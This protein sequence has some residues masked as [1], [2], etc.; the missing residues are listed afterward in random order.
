[1][2]AIKI[3]Y[4]K[5]EECSIIYNW[6]PSRTGETEVI[7]RLPVPII[8][9]SKELEL[10]NNSPVNSPVNSPINTPLNTPVNSP[11]KRNKNK[12]KKRAKI[13]NSALR[14][15]LRKEFNERRLL[16]NIGRELVVFYP[17]ICSLI[18]VNLRAEKILPFKEKRIRGDIYLFSLNKN[19]KI[20]KNLLE[21]I[22]KIINK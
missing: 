1:M 15:N 4:K 16:N 17:D 20:D 2:D 12:I 3:P 7:K 18:P 11:I 9:I 19:I 6:I 13:L 21:Y 8:Y 14:V 10:I 22:E 5:E